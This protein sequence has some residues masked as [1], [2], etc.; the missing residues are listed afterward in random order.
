MRRLFYF[1]SVALIV[2]SCH[3]EQTSTTTT[4][5]QTDTLKKDTTLNIAPVPVKD[6]ATTAATDTTAG[7]LATDS[8]A[9]IAE[10]LMMSSSTFKEAAKEHGNHKF[11]WFEPDVD[12][13]SYTFKLFED[14]PDHISTNA[15]IVVDLKQRQVYRYDVLLDSNIAVPFDHSLL[16]KI[17]Q[18]CR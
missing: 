5:Q 10:K 9:A 17:P 13:S 6:T 2:A 11:R 18:A 8:C 1:F 12:S 3:S 15:F 16:R 7:P 14:M 4:T